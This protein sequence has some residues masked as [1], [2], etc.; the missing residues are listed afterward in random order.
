MLTSIALIAVVAV[1]VHL[2]VRGLKAV[3]DRVLSPAARGDRASAA[4]RRHP[5]IATIVSLLVSS[6]IFA[7]WFAAVGLALSEL[8]V[9]LT[10][11]FATATIIGLAV[12]FGSQGLVQDVVIG[13]TMIFT[14]AMDIGDTVEVSGQV[15]RVERMG[16][17]FITLTNFIGQSVFIPNRNIGVVGRFRRGA[18]RAYVDVQI[19]A[20]TDADAL[21]GELRALA[22]AFRSQH[23]AI[24]SEPEVMGV[25]AAGTAGWRYVRLK[26]RIWPGQQ[27][28]VETILRQRL[29]AL[30]RARDDA[31]ADWMIS[32]T[33]RVA[34]PRP[35][36][37]ETP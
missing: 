13:L 17:R 6:A 11:Y 3:S 34:E 35:A 18:V 21:V 26:L 5:R 20:D 2:V 27:G 37:E 1:A 14:N 28:V 9:N 22:S 30:L 15:G 8:G 32:V 29:L 10:A 4:S 12:G 36:R 16:L 25:R 23:A 33:Y 24:L 7:L 31:Y 19:T